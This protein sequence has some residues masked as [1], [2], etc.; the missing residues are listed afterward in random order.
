M[1]SLEHARLEMVPNRIF[2]QPTLQEITQNYCSK[3][4]GLVYKVYPYLLKPLH[5][6]VA[7]VVGL[8]IG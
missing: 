1:S 8:A 4:G 2:S 3:H 7:S 6:F 5:Y